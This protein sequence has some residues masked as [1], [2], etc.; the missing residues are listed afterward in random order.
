MSARQLSL[1]KLTYYAELIAGCSTDQEIKSAVVNYYNYLIEN[2]H[3][4]GNLALQAA[5]NTGFAGRL[6]NQYLI[7]FSPNASNGDIDLF[8]RK[9][10]T[11]LLFRK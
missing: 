11:D 1:D 7:S 4:Y 9:K 10:G 6:A 8:N 2:E 3:W 5:T